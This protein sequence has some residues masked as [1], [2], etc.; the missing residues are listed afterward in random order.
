M[1]ILLVLVV[2]LFTGSA[3]AIGDLGVACG[4]IKKLRTWAVGSD[5]YGARC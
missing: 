3:L 4:E 1:K 5:T 2:A